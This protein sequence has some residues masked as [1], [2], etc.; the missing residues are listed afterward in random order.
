VL[1]AIG[2]FTGLF[3]LA[4]A[5]AWWFMIQMPGASYS[6]ELPPQTPTEATM[7]GELR[8][9]VDR[10]AG[11]IG[12]R[13]TDHPAALDAAREFVESSFEAAGFAVQRQ[14]FEADGRSVHNLEVELAGAARPGEIVIIGAH[15]DS[16]GAAPGADDN[17]S[18][19]AALFA[20]AR[21][22][23]DKKP[24]RTLRFVAFVN[25]EPPHF[26]FDSMGSL[27]YARRCRERNENVVAMLSLETVG[28][29][30]DTPG[31]QKYPAVFSLFYPSRGNF[32]AFVGNVGSRRLVRESI[33][34]F[35]RHAKF[36]SEGGA[37][38]GFIEGVAWSDHWAFWQ[39]GYP[40]IM[41]TDTAPFR[42]PHYHTVEDTP[43]KLDF[44]R[45]ARVVS[46]LTE[47]VERLTTPP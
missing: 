35:R 39:V 16:A 44:D 21:R 14:T 38:P 23:A 34:S 26:Q 5:L 2:V 29:F 24:A 17:A 4:L 19:V 30:R 18:G 31:S 33:G 32:I 41:V 11:D 12:P 20:L 3:V 25:E 42:N 22:F 36:P 8:R 46:G 7:S 1:W 40:A 45:M 27:V 28:Y 9:D 6:G 43:D 15:Y 13:N 47:V 10:L 37:V